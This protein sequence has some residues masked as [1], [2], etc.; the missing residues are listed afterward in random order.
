MKITSVFTVT[1]FL[2]FP[3]ILIYSN[4][5][6]NFKKRNSRLEQEGRELRRILNAVGEIESDNAVDKLEGFNA[7]LKD[8]HAGSAVQAREALKDLRAEMKRTLAASNEQRKNECKRLQEQYDNE[9][10]RI[11]S[12]NV[13]SQQAID[14]MQRV[15]NTL[16]AHSTESAL[17]KITQLQS[18]QNS[19]IQLARNLENGATAQ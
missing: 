4:D 16:G 5:K 14:D 13:N 10:Q 8:L 19:I 1:V 2:L 7:L 3:T 6:L 12:E 18:S 11:K 9:F 15:L 17:T